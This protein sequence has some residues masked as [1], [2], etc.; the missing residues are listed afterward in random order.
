M[1]QLFPC[2]L[3][4]L[5]LLAGGCERPEL[6]V[7]PRQ[8]LPKPQMVSLLIALHL[9]ESRV[10]G[11][12]LSTDSARALY[13]ELQKDLL[14]RRNVTD[15]AFRKSYR[16]YAVHGKDLDDIYGEVIDSL[17]HRSG[18]TGTIPPPGRY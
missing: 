11:A 8:L 5:T 9:L 1:K 7:P 10:D 16:Y 18:G 15:S 14:W 17:S 12:R 4:L 13:N 3:L 2:L 6:A